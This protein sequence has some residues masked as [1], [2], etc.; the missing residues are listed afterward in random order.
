MFEKNMYCLIQTLDNNKITNNII[1][2]SNDY[3]K[4]KNKKS[5]INNVN[6]NYAI[7]C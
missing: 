6:G 4:L 5:E 1:G 2:Y 3:D 7:I